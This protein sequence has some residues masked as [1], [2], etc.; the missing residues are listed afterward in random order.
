MR[1]FEGVFG[2]LGVCSWPLNGWICLLCARK[3]VRVDYTI[4]L[5]DMA[6]V[7]EDMNNDCRGLPRKTDLVLNIS[8]ASRSDDV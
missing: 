1:N 3:N 2:D 7:I 6:R 8:K 5:S 4:A